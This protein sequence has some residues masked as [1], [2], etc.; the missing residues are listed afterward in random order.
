MANTR[1][2][3]LFLLFVSAM[4]LKAQT[5]SG[6]D[7]I[8][9]K[10]ITPQ[11][12][13]MVQVYKDKA[14]YKAKIVWFDDTDDKARPMHTRLDHQNPN[15]ELRDRKILGMEVLSNLSYNQALKCWDSGVIYD[16]T[17]G[18]Q[19]ESTVSLINDNRLKVRGYWN[20]EFIGKSMYFTRVQELAIT[21]G[22]PIP[23]GSSPVNSSN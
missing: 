6:S 19:W 22:K 10:W 15:P 9:G 3:I 18:K 4:N 7:G 20:F 14:H 12:N 2:L 16:C 17:S 1:G 21:A 13:L 23:K 11:K 5:T 8:L